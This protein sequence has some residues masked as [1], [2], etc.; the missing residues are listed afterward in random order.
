MSEVRQGQVYWV[1]FGPSKGSSPADR[2]PCVVVQNDLF[3]RSAIATTVVCLITSNLIRAK[4]PGNVLLKKGEAGLTKPSVVN[5]S[6]ILTVDKTELADYS[7]RLS[8]S[9]AAAVR[10]GLHLL[11]ENL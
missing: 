3:N 10:D 4:A 7:G 1:D 9:S 2:H 5:V 8:Q 11:V 6:Q